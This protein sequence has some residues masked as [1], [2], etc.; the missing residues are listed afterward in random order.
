MGQQ[1]NA[2]RQQATPFLGQ[3]AGYNRSDTSDID[4]TSTSAIMTGASPTGGLGGLGDLFTTLSN[5]GSAPPKNNLIRILKPQFVALTAAYLTISLTT[6]NAETSPKFYITVGTG[7]SS[8]PSGLV[9]ATPTDQQIIDIH[10]RLKGNA[11]PYTTPNGLA[12]TITVSKLNIFKELPD[13]SSANFRGDCFVIGVHF[14]QTPNSGAGYKL[15]KFEVQMAGV[16]L[17]G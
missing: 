6:A 9:A 17:H 10:T 3:I 7:Y 14:L 11:T 5:V 1:D 12:G 2:L 15:N 8:N 16:I 13:P 4:V